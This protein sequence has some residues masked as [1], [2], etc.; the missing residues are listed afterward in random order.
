[1]SATYGNTVTDADI[2]LFTGVSGDINAVHTNQEFAATTAFGKRSV[3]ALIT[4]I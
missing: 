2:V 4:I 1:M 3:S